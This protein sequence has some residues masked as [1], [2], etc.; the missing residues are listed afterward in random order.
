MK[1]LYIDSQNLYLGLKELWYMIDFK[2]FYDYLQQKWFDEIIM[3]FWYNKE[4]KK[5]YDF[6]KKTWY[7]I[8]FKAHYSENWNMKAN[9]DIDIAIKSINDFRDWKLQNFYLISW[10]CDFISLIKYFRWKN[11]FWG[12]YVPNM[13]KTNRYLR[14]EAGVKIV[15][16]SSTMFSFIK[17]A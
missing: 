14:S 3:F 15:N 8:Y 6:L 7:K 2:L 11:I 16:L 1:I 9:V 4:N 17:N 10:D 5:L 12:L 13:A